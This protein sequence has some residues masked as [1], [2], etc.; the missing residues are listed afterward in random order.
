MLEGRAQGVVPNLVELVPQWSIP[1]A[2][3]TFWNEAIAAHLEQSKAREPETN[4]RIVRT[5]AVGSSGRDR[6]SMQI[7]TFFGLASAG[8]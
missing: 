5:V 1:W 4:Q 2:A 6:D 3:L 8:S 7:L